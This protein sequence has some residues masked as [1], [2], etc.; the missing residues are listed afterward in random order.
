MLPIV[1]HKFTA[2]LAIWPTDCVSALITIS[3]SRIQRPAINVRNSFQVP[4]NRDP[5]SLPDPAWGLGVSSFPGRSVSGLRCNDRTKTTI[6]STITATK[7]T[8]LT[9][10]ES[11]S[12]C[13]LEGL[14]RPNHPPDTQGMFATPNLLL[15]FLR[16]RST[17]IK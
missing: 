12:V 17:T 7:I 9:V 14:I 6:T 8:T 15:L 13:P 11:P 3:T 2:L 4:R 1:P 16:R 10:N 5:D